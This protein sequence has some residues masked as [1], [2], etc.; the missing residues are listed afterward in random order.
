MRLALEK[1][2]IESRPIWKPMHL[3]PV[4]KGCRIRGGAGSEDLFETGLCLPS[5]T[6]MTEEDLERVVNVLR[7]CYKLAGF[8]DHC[9]NGMEYS[10]GRGD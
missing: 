10:Q 2:N 5:G 6:Q 1:E 9:S 3:Q 7:R 8:E 4:F